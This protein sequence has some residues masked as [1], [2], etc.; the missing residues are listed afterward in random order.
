[1]RSVFPILMLVFVNGFASA[2]ETD[3]AAP[4]ARL[5]VRISAERNW[6]DLTSNMMVSFVGSAA[7]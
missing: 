3:I 1:M 7:G 6:P 2:V 5:A 4:K